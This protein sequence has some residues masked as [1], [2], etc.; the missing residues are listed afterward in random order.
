MKIERMWQ[1]A[2][3]C[4]V[5]LTLAYAAQVWH[6]ITRPTNRFTVVIDSGGRPFRLDAQTG[7]VW[8][9]DS[10]DARAERLAFHEVYDKEV[11]WFLDETDRL[12]DEIR[13]QA[14]KSGAP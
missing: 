13:R 7:R 1:V 9:L 12:R 2:L 4:L 11:R 6:G 3:W 5:I 14:G 8:L 10:K